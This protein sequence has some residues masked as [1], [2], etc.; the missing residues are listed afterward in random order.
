MRKKY[1]CKWY[2]LS[3][4]KSTTIEYHKQ[5]QLNNVDNQI[6]GLFFQKKEK[7]RIDSVM[8]IAI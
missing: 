7:Y 3:K 2:I 1:S 5:N 4:D 8:P 6:D